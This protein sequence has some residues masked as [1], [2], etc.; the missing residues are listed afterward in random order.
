IRAERELWQRLRN[1]RLDYKFKRQFGIGRYIVDF[2]C[3]EL[4]LV[5]EVDGATHTTDKELQYDKIRQKY[6]ESLGLTVKRYLNSDIKNNMHE[7]LNSIV[8][9]CNKL[10][11]LNQ[12]NNKTCKHVPPPCEG[13]GQ[14]EV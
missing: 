8:E 5:I 1:R 11:T 3:P 12:K 10:K 2:Y 4:K 13:G 7:V 9:A 14:E 6:L